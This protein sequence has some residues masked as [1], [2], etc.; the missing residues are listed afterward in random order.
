[1]WP[2]TG[3][4]EESEKFRDTVSRDCWDILMGAQNRVMEVVMDKK[5]ALKRLEMEMGTL[6]DTGQEAT[7][8]MS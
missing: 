4:Q 5:T 8:A 3:F 1:M 2:R 7:H 6:L